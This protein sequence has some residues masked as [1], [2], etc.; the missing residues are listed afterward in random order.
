MCNSA[1]HLNGPGNDVV[2]ETSV[3]IREEYKEYRLQKII[4]P[5]Q[6][7]IRTFNLGCL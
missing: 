2:C 5:K 4:E 6:F 1:A 3:K 7:H